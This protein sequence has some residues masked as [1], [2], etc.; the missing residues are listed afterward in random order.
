M[1]TYTTSIEIIKEVFDNIIYHFIDDLTYK[2]IEDS[3]DRG[4]DNDCNDSL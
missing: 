4:H 3:K 2:D 1:I